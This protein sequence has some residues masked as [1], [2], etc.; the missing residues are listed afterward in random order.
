MAQQAARQ[1]FPPLA[2]I[3]R[4]LRQLRFYRRQQARDM[5]VQLVLSAAIGRI[6]RQRN[7]G[8]VDRLAVLI[9]HKVPCLPGL[10]K[11]VWGRGSQYFWAFNAGNFSAWHQQILQWPV[12]VLKHHKTGLRVHLRTGRRVVVCLLVGQTLLADDAPQRA[13]LG[14]LHPYPERTSNDNG[15]H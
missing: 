6:N 1:R 3:C 9:G 14:W 7:I 13:R 8:V 15:G 11:E 4:I 12:T 2:V 10:L 5:N